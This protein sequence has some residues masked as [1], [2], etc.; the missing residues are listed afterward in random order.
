M[1]PVAVL[2]IVLVLF[3][4]TNPPLKANFSASILVSVKNEKDAIVDCLTALVAQDFG[5]EQMQIIVVD[6]NS[7]DGTLQRMHAFADES[8]ACI[9]CL[10]NPNPSKYKSSK[11]AAL[12][13]AVE[14][15]RG[16]ILLFTDADCRPEKG[17]V[18][19]MISM[20]DDS[21]GLVAGFSPQ[22]APGG[23]WGDVLQIDAA[24]AAFVAAGTIGLG[25]GVT[26]TGRNLAVRRRALFDIGGYAS[27]PDSL[28]GDDDFL[29]HNISRHPRWKV[30]YAFDPASVVP[31]AGPQNVRCFLQQKK[32]HLSAGRDFQPLSQ[33]LY[34]LFHLANLAI[35]LALPAAFYF[36]APLLL[37]PLAAKIISDY[38]CLHYFLNI[39]QKKI[40]LKAFLFW[41]PLFLFYNIFAGPGLFWGNLVWAADDCTEKAKV[42]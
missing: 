4:P 28:S 20:F 27:L 35:W 36:R 11:K 19:S 37:A 1:S 38:F 41:E 30:K 13:A 21:V 10:E 12:E 34:A 22:T 39:F 5:Q 18:R 33:F 2:F 29:L 3:W 9:H 8:I 6:D 17:W 15:A 25:R 23:F 16:D 31:A 14:K 40:H 42:S 24:S 7:S 26:C 32:R